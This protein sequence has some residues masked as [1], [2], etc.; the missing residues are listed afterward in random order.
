MSLNVGVIGATGMVGEEFLR[1]IEQRRFPVKNL[2]LFASKESKGRQVGCLGKNWTIETLEN[3][4]FEGLDLAFFSSG[5]EISKE[6]GPRAVSEGAFAID[7]SAAFRMDP[8]VHLIV[9]EINGDLLSSS[10][11]PTLIANPN[12]STIQL[13]M[14]LAPLQKDF[15]ISQIKVATYQSVSGAGKAARDEL[16]AQLKSELSSDSNTE[17]STPHIPQVFA[18]PIAFNCL[19]H[20]GGFDNTGFSSEELKIIKE[21]KKI[22]RDPR[23]S[24]SA[25]TVRV[26]T[27]NGHSEVAWVKLN[28]SV[29][30]D[31]LL[32]SWSHL[33]AVEIL[34]NPQE[35]VYP[36]TRQASGHDPVYIGRIHRDFD[37]PL[38]W[39]MWIVADNLRVGAALNG[40]RIAEKIFR[41]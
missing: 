37:D 23:L 25:F 41:L 4:C 34:D 16:L 6:W 21:T 8:N 12:C 30:R 36:T 14:A 15:G 26:P 35:A 10:S 11:S 28:K 5:D 38:T 20:I 29:E 32:R 1:L 27:L 39:V 9:P 22:L 13:V 19:P 17:I 2:K 40:I 33:S 24:V 3:G 7:N 18:H 31:D